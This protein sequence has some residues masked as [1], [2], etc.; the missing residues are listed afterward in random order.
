[1]VHGHYSVE[2]K[3]PLP[4]L[5]QVRGGQDELWAGWSA[6]VQTAATAITARPVYM[7]GMVRLSNMGYERACSRHFVPF[8]PGWRKK[9]ATLII[10]GDL[11][12]G[13][14]CLWKGW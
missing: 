1:M 11:T 3:E 13:V 12:G 10:S 8:R 2:V 4:P 9:G 5:Y 7:D 6:F 14:V